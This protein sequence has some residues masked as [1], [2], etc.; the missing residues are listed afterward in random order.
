MVLTIHGGPYAQYPATLFDEALVYAR[1]GWAV[2]MCNPRGGSGYDAE[3]GRAIKGAMGGADVQD[4]FG[5]LDECLTR[6]E[7]DAD[8][9]GIMGGS[10]GGLMTTWILGHTDRFVAGISERAVNAWDSFA[11]TSD[12]GFFFGEK[13]VGNDLVGKSPLDFAH[14]IT[15]PTMIIHSER[16]FRGPLEQGQRLYAL[17]RSRAVPTQLLIFPGEGHELS[18]SGQPRH[19]KQQRAGYVKRAP[20]PSDARARLA[21]VTDHGQAAIA[22]ASG[23]VAQVED[24]WRAQLGTKAYESMRSALERLR[25][26]TDP[27]R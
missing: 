11:D 8:R 27:Y 2:V 20:D 12:I 10:Y 19:R 1:A 26:L 14:N 7:L 23:A 21:T 24:E 17:L 25:E 6:P 9:V 15:T 4:I 22:A 13:Y 18:R 16:D 5:F 3:H